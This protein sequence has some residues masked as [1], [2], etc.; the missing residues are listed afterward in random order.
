MQKEEKFKELLKN[1]FQ[2]NKDKIDLD[3][4]VYRVF[5]HKENEIRNFIETKLPEYIEENLDGIEPT[6]IY[7]HT[8]EFFERYFQDGDFYPVP[9]YSNTKNHILRHNGEEVIFSWANKDQYYIKSI[10]NFSI[11]KIK[12][13]NLYNDTFYTTNTQA[14]NFVV[15]EID[16][17]KGNN[18]STR[19]FT[20]STKSAEFLENEGFNI[21][22]DYKNKSSDIVE[23][24][25][26]GLFEIISNAKIN[27][28][29]EE[30]AHHL[31]KFKN[32][33]KTD[34]FIHKRLEAFLKEELD[35]YLKT[36]ILRDITTL[37]EVDIK[38]TQVVK[39][40]SEFIIKFIA[41]LEELQ[42][43]LWEKKKFAYDVN[44]IITLDKLS[45]ELLEEITNHP[46]FTKQ[47]DEWKE[48]KLINEF[49]KDELYDGPLSNLKKEYKYLPLDTKNLEDEELKYKILES[50]ENLDEATDGVLINSDNFHG[51]N[52]LQNRYKEKVKCV[53][54]DPPYNTGDDGFAY[55][56]SYKDSSWLSLMENRLVLMKKMFSQE[57]PLFISIDD[58]ELYNLKNLMNE[59]FDAYASK[60]IVVKTAEPTGK[61]MA[62]VINSGGLAKLKEYVLVYKKDKINGFNFERIPKEG[63]D[64]EYK[65]ILINI[66]K[67][68]MFL[69]K[70]IRDNEDF[71]EINLKKV[72]KI[73]SKIELIS[74]SDYATREKVKI[75][76]EW[77]YKNAWRIVRDASL[78]GGAKEIADSKN[79]TIDSGKIFY[80]LTSQQKMYFIKAGYNMQVK[81]P[82]VKLL[83]ADDYL[84]LHCGDFWNDIK[85]TG[86]D[87]EGYI[88]FLNGKKPLKLIN[89]LIDS[90]ISEKKYIL[91]FFAG[92]GTTGQAVIQ[93]NINENKKNSF[94]LCEA[95][96][97]FDSKL[98]KRILY[99]V[100]YEKY[101]SLVKYYRLEQYEDTLE[102][103]KLQSS[104]DTD[105]YIKALEPLK[106]HM[107]E[108]YA[109]KYM[110]LYK[111][112]ISR[113][114]KAL[115]MDDSIFFNPFNFTLRVNID[116]QIVEKKMDLVETFNTLKGIE[117][118]GMKLRYL[119]D[120]KY[121][122]V[123]GKNEVVIWRE[124]DKES[125]DIT[126]ELEFIKENCTIEKELYINGI[127]Q[128]H[129]KKELVAKESIFELRALLVEGVKIDE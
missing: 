72:E 66:K 48:L 26:N 61:K 98:K 31:K 56:D 44:Y 93:N 95:N 117:V 81:S 23:V 2:Y 77:K 7:N 59:Y 121:I 122:F 18:K 71:K 36:N 5:K 92:S 127:T 114:S 38:T 107:S 70:N 99:T 100:Y 88:D 106:E 46:N 1:I 41:S 33:R 129:T 87:N 10:D 27:L 9:I 51:L 35:Y 32:L 80:I 49:K 125:L 39:K 11:Y 102:N 91:D 53:Y 111:D 86:L 22:I 119:E 74:L 82:R 104:S 123:D 57:T 64:S 110:S 65:S 20:L 17:T 34:F 118:Q 69:L 60:T 6:T 63:W 67:E 108:L 103:S 68:D 94:L 84:T 29:L 14:V 109:S 47:I 124:F 85:T 28:T 83:F 113:E 89:R 62:S 78:E 25:E 126:K 30:I 79:T 105:S 90:V 101:S 128:T 4:G 24:D 37:S 42:K 115:L 12:H 55:K 19:I 120:K 16:D 54:I 112:F 43:M 45:H 8:L 3:F 97:Y 13:D 21:Y 96:E 15:D 50:I 52:F 73:L 116:S 76:D 75:D 58:R 40:V